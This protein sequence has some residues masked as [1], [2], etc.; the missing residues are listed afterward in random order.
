M[1]EKSLP[2]NHQ[3]DYAD[4]AEH[5]DA[6][7]TMTRPNLD[8]WVGAIMKLGGIR[9]ES[10]VLE[11]GCGTGRFALALREKTYSRIVAIDASPDMLKRAKTKPLAGTIEW[12]RGRAENI[13]LKNTAFDC[14]F[15]VFALHQFQDKPCALSEMH[16][17][18]RPGG[19]LVI[20]TASHGMLKKDIAFQL[21]P[22]MLRIE[23]R[24][25]PSIPKLRRLL[26]AAGFA[27]PISRHVSGDPESVSK[28]TYREWILKKPISTFH[29]LSEE[30]FN[31]GLRRFNSADLTEPLPQIFVYHS[32][33]M[34][35]ATKM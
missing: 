9:K 21:F 29:M 5:Y 35:S 11:V 14:V 12:R 26:I 24:R 2:K 32:C 28:A 19:R 17:L 20:A 1:A 8:R 13:P 6:L 10:N 27:D 4:L 25:F 15:T 30:S 16:R 23:T 3:T 7:R 34:V 18:L 22:E 33:L 31:K